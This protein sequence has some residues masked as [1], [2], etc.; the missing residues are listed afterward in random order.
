CGITK[1][2]DT[3]GKRFFT[4]LAKGGA[5]NNVPPLENMLPKYYELRGWDANG[6]PK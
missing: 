3:Y 5:R 1:A 6:I 4:P 2:D